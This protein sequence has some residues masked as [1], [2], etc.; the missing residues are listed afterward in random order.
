MIGGFW[1]AGLKNQRYP[2]FA[3][4]AWIPL[5]LFGLLIVLFLPSVIV[6]KHPV[7]AQACLKRSFF[8]YFCRLM[9][10]CMDIVFTV[11]LNAADFNSFK[12]KQKTAIGIHFFQNF[13]RIKQ[14]LFFSNLFYSHKLAG[15]FTRVCWLFSLYVIIYMQKVTQVYSCFILYFWRGALMHSAVRFIQNG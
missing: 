8:V 13:F 3:A 2:A 10:C 14:R 7:A 12:T 9:I 15:T 11:F 1:S 4:L 6:N 5:T